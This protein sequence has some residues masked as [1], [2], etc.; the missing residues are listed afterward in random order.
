MSKQLYETLDI[1]IKTAMANLHTSTVAIVTG[2]QATT[3]SCQPVIQRSVDGRS[4]TLPEFIEVPPVFMQGGYS[5]TAHPIAVGDY[6]L[7]VFSERCFDRWYDGIDF[8]PPAEYRMHDYSDGFAF[9]GINPRAKAITIPQVIT[10]I[11]DTYQDGSYEHLGNRTQTGNQTITGNVV[12]NGSLTVNAG[13]GDT[14]TVN[15]VTLNIV[16]GDVIADGISL[17]GHVHPGDSGGTT[18]APQ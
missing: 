12:I 17:K 13:V 16:S 9:V 3:I 15:G 4:I 5:Y 18:G 14:V 6:C 8:R 1:A 2:V 7:L 11:G 10:Q